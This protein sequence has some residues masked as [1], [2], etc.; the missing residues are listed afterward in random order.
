M[1]KRGC[2]YEDILDK[3]LPYLWAAYTKGTFEE[4]EDFPKDL[5]PGQFKDRVVANI[6]NLLDSGHA[7][8]V[9]ICA[10]S[11]GEIPIGLIITEFQPDYALPHAYWFPWA[12]DRNKLEFSVRYLVDLKAEN[13]ILI[14]VS[15]TLAPF[16]QHL[17]K[18]GILRRIGTIKNWK[19][20]VNNVL[21]Q[22]VR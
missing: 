1:L 2:A 3:H 11:E 18:Y 13:L 8:G 10:T 17:G 9:G 7:M 6:Y 22:S 5:E 12:S 19:P 21:F 4:L 14:N 15:E 20:G 16:F